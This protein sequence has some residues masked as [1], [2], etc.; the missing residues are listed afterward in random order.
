MGGRMF[1]KE[2]IIATLKETGFDNNCY[3]VTS[4]AGA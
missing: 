2:K 1:D 4:G 3:W